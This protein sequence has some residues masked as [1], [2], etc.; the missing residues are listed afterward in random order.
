MK[1]LTFLCAFLLCGHLRAQKSVSDFQLQD[2]VNGQ[3][4]SLTKLIA[5]KGVVLVFTGNEC[6]FDRYYRERLRS[7]IQQYEKTIAFVFINSYGE[8][9]ESAEAMKTEFA[10]WQLPVPY[11]ADKDQK[12]LS[13]F[14]VRKSPEVVVLKP[15]SGM[16]TSIYQGALDDSPQAAESVEVSY[17]SDALEALLTGGTPPAGA[18]AVGCTIRRK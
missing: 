7:V 6:P 15:G 4:F 9:T 14:E 1:L 10:T 16:F 17:L 11:L 18:R 3:P 12:V 2:V 8:P 13:I 5:R